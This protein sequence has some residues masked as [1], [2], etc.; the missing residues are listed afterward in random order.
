M[1]G[2]STKHA[3]TASRSCRLKDSTYDCSACSSTVGIVVTPAEGGTARPGCPKDRRGGSATRRET[4]VGRVERDG[5]LD[6]VHRVTY[7]REALEVL[8]RERRR[9]VFDI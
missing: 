6:I 2:S 9:R 1:T 4:Q 5:G 8:L 7:G 3:S